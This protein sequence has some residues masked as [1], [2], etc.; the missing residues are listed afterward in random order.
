M[1]VVCLKKH[2]I[3]TTLILVSVSLTVTG[4]YLPSFIDQNPVVSDTD[5]EYMGGGGEGDT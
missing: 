1:I 3:L 2:Y 5:L 4:T